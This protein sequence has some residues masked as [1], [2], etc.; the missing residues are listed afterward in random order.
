M[1]P[2]LSTAR[3]VPKAIIEREVVGANAEAR[4]I[5]GDAEGHAEQILET[6]R[7]QAEELRQRGY[8]EGYQE[9]LGQYTEQTLAKLREIE[10]I[11]AELEPQYVGLVRTCVER[12]LGQE[13]KLHPDAIV[14]IV[15]NALRDAVQQRE[16][17]VRIHPDDA[18]Q[19]KK[20]QRRLL[21][22]LARASAI[23][24]R[25]DPSVTRA[26]CVV[27]TE[28]GLIDASLERQL[29]AIEKVLEDELAIVNAG[30][31]AAAEAPQEEQYEEEEA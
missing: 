31:E 3:P 14:G 12:I 13:M 11:K 1:R 28:L 21:E 23:E 18:D 9:G 6:A 8:D 27:I 20:N 15:R 5:K 10:Q 4:R 22:V 2:G 16:I 17:V 26:G 25:E 30:M 24:V 19:L 7:Q 29:K